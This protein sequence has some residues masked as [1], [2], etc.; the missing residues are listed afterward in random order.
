MGRRIMIVD[1]EPSVRSS[2]KVLLEDKYYVIEAENGKEALNLLGK[3]SVDLVLLDIKMEDVDGIQVLERIKKENL[4]LN[5]IMVTVERDI[6]KVIDTI[7]LGAYDYITKPFIESNLLI[8]IERALENVELKRANK[9]FESEVKDKRKYFELVGKSKA[10]VEIYKSIEKFSKFDTNVLVTGETGVGKELVARA[11][12]KEGPRANKPF[13]AINCG[14]MPINLI[15]SELF[16]HEPGAYTGATSRR[17]GKFEIANGGIIFL[18]EISELNLE[19]QVKLLRVIQSGEF[20]R[21]GGNK[22]IYTDVRIIA[23][24]NQK[25]EGL[26]AQNKFRKDLFYR[27]KVVEINIPPLRERKEDI[28]ILVKHFIKKYSQEMNIPEKKI[29]NEVLLK[30]QNLS[31]W[32]GNIRELENKVISASIVAEGSEITLDNFFPKHSDKI[33]FSDLTPY[34]I[35]NVYSIALNKKEFEAKR[36]EIKREI[37]KTFDKLFVER[38]LEKIGGDVKNAVK[39]T[40][41]NRTYFYYLLRRSGIDIKDFRES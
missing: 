15:E 23:A 32:E 38:L 22:T 26:I 6:Q 41:M 12:H 10:M 33:E 30:L 4:P 8:S 36:K 14:A 37:L 39:E 27:I 40:G 2:L 11:I 13:I 19:A 7:K 21:L 9:Y 34:F 28:P 25:L 35:K 18:D 24:T 29:S 16:G 3:V 5:V 20:T 1:D 17:E 31:D